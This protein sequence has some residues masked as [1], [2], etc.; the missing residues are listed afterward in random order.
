MPTNLKV[1][2][3]IQTQNNPIKQDEVKVKQG[4]VM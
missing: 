2:Y 3:N 4:S 1:P